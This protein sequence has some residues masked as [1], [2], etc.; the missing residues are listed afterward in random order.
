MSDKERDFCQYRK[1]KEKS[2]LCYLGKGLCDKH[3]EKLCELD[4]KEMHRKLGIEDEKK[5][6]RLSEEK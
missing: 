5:L 4:I 2:N 1:C 3:W 6:Y